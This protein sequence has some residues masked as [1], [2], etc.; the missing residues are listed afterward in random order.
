MTPI[1]SEVPRKALDGPYEFDTLHPFSPPVFYPTNE[2]FFA[3]FDA[4]LDGVAE[5]LPSDDLYPVRI[6][7]NRAALMVAAMAYRY[8]IVLGADGVMRTGPAYGEVMIAAPVTVGEPSRPLVPLVRLASTPWEMEVFVLHLPV[9][10][11]EAWEAGRKIW[12]AP[13][14]VADMHFDLGERR[15]IITLSEGGRTVLQ[16]A[17]RKGG[18]LSA[19]SGTVAIHTSKDGRLLRSDTVMGGVRSLRLGRGGAA[20]RWGSHEVAEQLRGLDISD[21]AAAGVT[22]ERHHAQLNGPEP[23]GEARPYDGLLRAAEPE[24]GRFVIAYPGTPPIDV[25]AVGPNDNVPVEPTG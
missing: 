9:T 4:D 7:P 21:T 14:F 1:D 15:S 5:L 2:V 18:R 16:M 13:K 19:D 10:T 22:Y 11:V 17:V 20:I 24:R 12:N 8:D 23:V 25:C 6:S 3:I